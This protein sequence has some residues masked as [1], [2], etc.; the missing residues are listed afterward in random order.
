MIRLN[1]P[2]SLAR[3]RGTVVAIG[4]FGM[5][6]PRK[7]YYEKELV[8]KISRSYGPGRYDPQYEEGGI[9]LSGWICTL[10]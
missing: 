5:D 2:A 3:D 1:W 8:F 7:M 4:A 6:I 10:D 9:G